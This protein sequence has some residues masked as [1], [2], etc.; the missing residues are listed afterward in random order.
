M[1]A[2]NPISSL[3]VSGTPTKL[4]EWFN[5]RESM[6]AQGI[7][8]EPL[9]HQKN[10]LENSESKTLSLEANGHP[11]GLNEWFDIRETLQQEGIPLSP[12][13]HQQDKS[14]EVSYDSNK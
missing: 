6:K 10:K 2:E 12:L 4:E 1:S 11:I 8:L 14:S 3:Q 13:P 5:Q 9:P 7:P